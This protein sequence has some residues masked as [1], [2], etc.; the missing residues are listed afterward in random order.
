M[1]KRDAAVAKR[2]GVKEA[3]DATIAKLQQDVIST[4]LVVRKLESE[5]VDSNPEV[6]AARDALKSAQ[7]EL[8]AFDA[9]ITEALKGDPE[10]AAAE[11]RDTAA[12]QQLV[13]AKQAAAQAAKAE[14]D[15][16]AAAAKS[17]SGSRGGGSRSGGG[18]Y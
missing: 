9:Q 12:Q 3:D 5:Q 1:A 4:G 16:R 15:S 17:K 18:R 6:V 13:A 7:E 10:Y 14:A 8:R 2:D 11:Q